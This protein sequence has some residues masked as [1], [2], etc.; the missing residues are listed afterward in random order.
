MT[1]CVIHG[2]WFMTQRPR[3]S[4]TV[5]RDRHSGTM[6]IEQ[7]AVRLE[8]R[9]IQTVIPVAEVRSV[10]WFRAPETLV[11]LLG[12]ER[13]WA[14]D[15]SGDDVVNEWIEVRYG[16][17]TGR[18]H[19]V[20]IADGGWFGWRAILRRALGLATAV[21]VVLAALREAFESSDRGS[22]GESRVGHSSPS[23]PS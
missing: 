21:D 11:D 2:L 10:G 18:D 23:Q 9:R 13:R 14:T 4:F 19:V 6:Y 22:A 20:Y 15:P 1:S 3:A 16:D 12:D 8:G 17:A 7:G 5:F